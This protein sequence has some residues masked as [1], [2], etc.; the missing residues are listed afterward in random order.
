MTGALTPLTTDQFIAAIAAD[1]LFVE[2]QPIVVRDPRRIV[3]LEAL[4]RWQHP[5]HGRLEPD[6][7][8]D[9]AERSAPAIDALTCGV[10][11][12]AAR[13]YG[14]LVEAGYDTPIAVN[15][16]G[17]NLDARDFPERVAAILRDARVPI[18]RFSLELT[19]TAAFAEHLTSIDVF[20]RLRLKGL[21]LAIDDFGAGF[22][23]LKRL[24]QLPFSTIKIDRSFI[25]DLPQ[26]DAV[27]VVKSIVDLARNMQLDCIAE[28]I[29][30]AETASLLESLGVTQ[31]QGDHFA[32]PQSVE[33]TV[34][35]LAD[36][37]CA[38]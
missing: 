5:A 4:V 22:S 36:W 32:P 33:Q 2:Y 28:G 29:E 15:I 6:R 17:R 21:R 23:S 34:A 11:A 12:R 9:L 10:L 19:E 8:I 24:K 1:E 27:A 35:W 3:M 37:R 31:L 14:R 16:S 30:S 13:D 18:G 7:F 38:A 26:R 20:A 25:A